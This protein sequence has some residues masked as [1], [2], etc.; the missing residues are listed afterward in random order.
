MYR[1]GRNFV[2]FC[3]NTNQNNKIIWQQIT[4]SNPVQ[5]NCSPKIKEEK[6]H[7]NL[8]MAQCDSCTLFYST[9]N[10]AKNIQIN[11][12]AKKLYKRRSYNWWNGFKCL[13]L[14]QWNPWVDHHSNLVV[15]SIFNI[16]LVKF[17]VLIF[18]EILAKYRLNTDSKSFQDPSEI[19]SK[20]ATF[21]LN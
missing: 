8:P 11:S 14:L 20:L 15:N 3:P 18:S 6:S 1:N 12:C 19:V 5:T 9:I 4:S 13:K 16:L 17:R 2:I 10:P 7:S 21:H